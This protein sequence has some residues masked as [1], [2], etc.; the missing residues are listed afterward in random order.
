M[1]N[2]LW[3]TER[4]LSKLERE[5]RSSLHLVINASKGTERYTI[6]HVWTI[7]LSEYSRIHVNSSA[8]FVPSVELAIDCRVRDQETRL[9]W[10]RS[11]DDFQHELK[12]LMEACFVFAFPCCVAFRVW[13]SKTLS[14]CFLRV[15]H[16]DF[17]AL[18]SMWRIF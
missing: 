4:I 18:R 11:R 3:K 1:W 5:I 16:Y 8:S 2:Y 17:M 10:S 14:L 6:K 15:N 9:L 7:N 13:T 12:D